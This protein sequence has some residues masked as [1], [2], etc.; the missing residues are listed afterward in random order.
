[1]KNF[2]LLL[3][4]LSS[5]TFAQTNCSTKTSS[6]KG[7]IAIDAADLRCIAK[8]SGKK[9]TLFYTF[10]IWCEPCRLHLP[11]AIKIARQFNIDLY[12]IIV[13]AE[14]S[15]KASDAVNYLQKLDKD[16][17]I[18]IYKNSVYGEKTGKRNRKFVK[19]ITPA[20]FEM[21]DDYSKYIL[22]D[23]KGEVL[24]V[25]TW[26]DNKG[27]DWRDDSKMTDKKIVPLLK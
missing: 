26:K 2:C 18:A 14:G 4:F 1:M 16:I 17:K 19:E 11:N 12:V 9:N 22:L 6:T 13:D 21:I 7:A 20:K 27:N 23:N 15:K 8:N 3:I 25:T 10:G 5:I 24:M